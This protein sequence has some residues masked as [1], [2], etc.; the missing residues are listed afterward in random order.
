MQ[1]KI[2]AK[3]NWFYI[4]KVKMILMIMFPILFQTSITSSLIYMNRKEIVLI[5]KINQARLKI[6]MNLIY[7]DI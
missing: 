2:M 3:N 6:F 4:V 5:L 1:L 7:F